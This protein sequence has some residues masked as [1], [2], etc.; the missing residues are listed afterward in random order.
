VVLE[1]AAQQPAD[2]EQRVAGAASMAGLLA[3]DARGY[4]VHGGESRAG[5]VAGIQHPYR[6]R[7]GRAKR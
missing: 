5:D 1:A 7:Q 4:V 3:L 6:V 2:A